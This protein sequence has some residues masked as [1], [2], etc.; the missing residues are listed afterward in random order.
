MMG[1]I[2]DTGIR[3]L[4]REAVYAEVKRYITIINTV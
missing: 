2:E 3:G 1:T 4:A